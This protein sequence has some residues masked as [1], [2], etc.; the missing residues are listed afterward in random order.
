VPHG[1]YI[2]FVSG[3]ETRPAAPQEI[4]AALEPAYTPRV[5]KR[6]ALLDAPEC[7][8][9]SETVL[10][11]RKFWTQRHP[12]APSYTLGAA[13]YLDLSKPFSEY[14]RGAIRGNNLLRR[15]F[16]WLYERLA[17]TLQTTFGAKATYTARYA[18]PGFHIFEGGKELRDLS[19][20][21]HFD[22]QDMD[23]D[24]DDGGARPAGARFSF[25]LP[26]TVPKAGAGLYVWNISYEESQAVDEEGLR[27]LAETRTREYIDYHAGELVI[28]SGDQLH[29]I[30]EDRMPE[31][32]EVRLTL[33]GHGR[34]TGGSWILYW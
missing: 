18:L 4:A 9:I 17:D 23:L 28:H 11:M 16:I 7:A 21:I 25:T 15:R 10:G 33:Q 26:I 32:G 29:Q 24:W 2:N 1:R 14:L 30:A 5:L 6:L 22:L 13:S 31:S 34:L 27:T 3:V 8:L 19:A 20:R 12:T